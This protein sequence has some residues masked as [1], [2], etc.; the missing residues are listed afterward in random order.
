MSN[1]KVV[2]VPI[3]EFIPEPTFRVSEEFVMNMGDHRKIGDVLRVIMN[4]KM[5]EKTKSFSTLRVNNMTL[6]NTKRII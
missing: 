2:K 6:F 1:N 4:T 5:L 3:C